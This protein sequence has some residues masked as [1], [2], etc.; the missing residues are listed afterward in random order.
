MSAETKPV[1]T[2]LTRSTW[3]TEKSYE[4]KSMVSSSISQ[5]SSIPEL[6]SYL[7]SAFRDKEFS[8]V[9]GILMDREKHLR[10]EI[11]NL[12]RDF[13]VKT[14]RDLADKELVIVDLEKLYKENQLKDMQRKYEEVKNEKAEVEAK[15]KMYLEKF[16]ELESRVSLQE[17]EAAQ[18]RA[19]D[20]SVIRKMVEDLE[21]EDDDVVE[22]NS[23]TS[24]ADGDLQEK[25][26]S[27]RAPSVD[28]TGNGSSKSRD[29]GIMFIC[30]LLTFLLQSL[31][32][33]FSA[34]LKLY[35]PIHACCN[36][37]LVVDALVYMWN[38]ICGRH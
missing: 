4:L 11:Q 36:F 10:T 18:N 34:M 33:S 23:K 15:L 20:V 21:A 37:C 38:W 13:S 22:V 27:P 5:A 28:S 26:L 8:L 9:E 29:E 32:E 19:V 24:G 16:K 1:I 6:I 12:K 17:E 30:V 35:L 2:S 3:N 7:K 31:S 25:Q 14:G